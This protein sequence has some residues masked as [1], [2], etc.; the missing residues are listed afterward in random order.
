MKTR[1]NG[2]VSF[3]LAIA[4]LM[5][6]SILAAANSKTLPQAP[7]PSQV[8]SAKKV[9]IANAGEDEMIEGQPGFSGTSDR[10]YNQFYAAIKSW[11]H[12]QIVSSPAEADLLLEIEVTVPVADPLF[13][14][15]I[16][17][18]KTNALLWG[19]KLHTQFGLGQGNSDRNFDQAVNRLAA[20]LQG[21][22]ARGT[23]PSENNTAQ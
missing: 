11:G 5:Q 10:A 4:L 7:L 15:T 13:R 18:P 20:E 14:L 16:R 23:S 3:S 12:Y 9:F 19:F 17:D 21:L 6:A 8:L 2:V 1:F 22:V